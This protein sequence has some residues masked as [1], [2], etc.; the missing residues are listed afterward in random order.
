MRA[1]GREREVAELL[2]LP[3]AGLRVLAGSVD[4]AEVRRDERGGP[5]AG[6]LRVPQARAERQLER[7][8]RIGLGQAEA[9]GPHLELGEQ[10]QRE[11]LMVEIAAPACAVELGEEQLAG[12][13]EVAV[14]VELEPED[15][16]RR[17]VA[18]MRVALALERV[19]A[20]QQLAL[21]TLAVAV[22]EEREAAQRRREQCRRC[23]RP[24]HARRPARR[25][26]APIS[27]SPLII[28]NK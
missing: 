26:A 16:G 24:R 8:L 23:L 2:G 13:G 17:V 20:Q 12:L 11:A 9:P 4:P 14:D 21:H 19:G 3:E 25:A 5:V 15:L 18:D 6:R 10:Q 28:W 27:I 7:P 1:A 22:T